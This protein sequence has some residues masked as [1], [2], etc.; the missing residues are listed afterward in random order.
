M[1]KMLK[2]LNFIV[3]L[4]LFLMP[5]SPVLALEFNPNYV[6]SDEDLT[7]YQSMTLDDIQKFLERK[8]SYLATYVSEDTDG[9]MKS[10]SE[11][12]HRVANT[13]YISP[14][15]LLALIQ[16][17]QSLVEDPTPTQKQLDWAAGYAVCDSCTTVDEQI[18]RWRGFAKQI[19]SAAMQYREGYL[20]D[21]AENGETA[22]GYGP[23]KIIEI[24]NQIVIPYNN[25]TAANYTYT[26]HIHGNQSLWNI[27]QRWFTQLYP[28][29]SLL[30]AAGEPGIWL[31]QYGQKRPFYSMAALLSRYDIGNVIPVSKTDL[32]QYETGKPIKFP[33]YSLLR[34]PR[35]TIF[36]LDDDKLRGIDSWETFKTIGFNIDEV[37]DVEWSDINL[38]EPGETITL[39]SAYPQ[40]ALLQ[41]K[42]T[43][44]V[45]W[46]QDG[47]KYPIWSREIMATRFG[48][49]FIRQ[50]N[51]DELTKYETMPPVGFNEGTLVKSPTNPGVYVISEGMRRPIPSADVFEGMGYK[52]ENIITT[53]EKALSLHEIGEPLYLLSGDVETANN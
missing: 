17:E 31:I 25:A 14:K 26:P 46:I 13:W 36:L 22:A 44:G 24:D 35:G 11:I 50:V 40:G 33:E 41:D 8:G 52:W 2:I 15:F 7:N 23:G 45:Y 53:S 18:Q 38:Y 34:S 32:D 43:G 12:I 19:R 28:N 16:K 10:A 29:G 20:I 21:L 47:K 9:L 48:N 30:Q 6:L 1:K 42:S 27:W 4:S 5:I 49:W 37:I 39:K 3:I 51:T